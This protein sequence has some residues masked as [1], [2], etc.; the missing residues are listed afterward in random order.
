MHRRARARKLDQRRF[1]QHATAGPR[2]LKRTSYPTVKKGHIV[3]RLLQQQFAVEERVAVHIDGAATCVLNHVK[4]AGTRGPFY[5]RFRPSG[6]PTDDFEASLNEME[7][8]VAP[9]LNG[10]VEQHRLTNETKVALTQLV[11]MQLVRGP[12]FVDMRTAIVRDGL[13]GATAEDFDP[14]A[15]ARFGGDVEKVRSAAADEWLAPSRRLIEMAT[16]AMTLASVLGHMRW[17]LVAFDEPVLAYCDQPV[18]VWPADAR[19]RAAIRRPQIGPLSAGEVRMPLSP[20]LALLLTWAD[21]RSLP[22]PLTARTTHAALINAQTVAQ[23]DRQWMHKPGVEPPL[24][25]GTSGSLAQALAQPTGFG[26][27]ARRTAATA[28]VQRHSGRKLPSRTVAVSMD[29]P[30]T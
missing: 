18:T 20:N 11:G 12:L 14:D 21:L 7:T 19:T 3:P 29:L 8:R 6:E 30:S 22:Q 23:A 1:H 27:T 17:S 16:Y 5:R 15:L 24:G 28:F 25:D 13:A 26:A 9:V 4:D 2:V 10:V